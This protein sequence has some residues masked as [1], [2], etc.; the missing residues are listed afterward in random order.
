M[1]QRY[2]CYLLLCVQATTKKKKHEASAHYCKGDVIGEA[3][4]L[5][6]VMGCTGKAEYGECNTAYVPGAKCIG[7]NL[8]H[9]L[10]IL[11]L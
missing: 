7:C 1:Y 6:F 8:L 3:C 2:G 4:D 9:M 11:V 10:T 5:K